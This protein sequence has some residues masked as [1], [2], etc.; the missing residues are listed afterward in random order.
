MQLRFLTVSP[1]P[2][3]TKQKELLE[4]AYLQYHQAD[5]IPNDPISIPHRFSIKQDIEIMG[6][7]AALLA[8]GQRKTIVNKGSELI[9]Y[10]ENQ[11]FG[12]IKNHSDKDL[13]QLLKFVHRTFNSTD[14]LYLIHFLKEVYRE[15][16]SL[17]KAF[18]PNPDNSLFAVE[19][20]LNHFKNR[21]ISSDFFPERTGKHVAS[22]A[23]G[24]ACKRLNMF[25]RWM[26][27]KDDKGID[28]GIWQNISPAQLICPLDL[29]VLRSANILGLLNDSKSDW[30]NATA[31]TQKLRKFDSDDPAKYDFALF[32][33][34]ES[35][36]LNQ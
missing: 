10:F 8:W 25:L 2:T 9:R 32:G 7:F 28:F 3:A 26:V 16:D 35:G 34:S 19:R 14:L 11:P 21:F 24:S 33:L 30:K 12:F 13:K 5:F 22:P 1:H 4:K 15:F 27:R 17:E 36:V 23:Q 6:L 20:G 29:H 18:F 31:L